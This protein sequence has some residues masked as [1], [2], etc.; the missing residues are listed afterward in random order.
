[1]LW[2]KPQQLG[3]AIQDLVSALPDKAH[4]QMEPQSI[5]GWLPVHCWRALGYSYFGLARVWILLGMA[6]I[7]SV[8]GYV[9][10]TGSQAAP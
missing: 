7:R 10:A 6:C 1:M 4:V 2:N 8:P 9:L 3:R 5:K